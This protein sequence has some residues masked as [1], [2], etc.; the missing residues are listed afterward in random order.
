MRKKYFNDE[1]TGVLKVYFVYI[2]VTS[3]FATTH[4]VVSLRQ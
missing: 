1:E 3:G 2:I 4:V